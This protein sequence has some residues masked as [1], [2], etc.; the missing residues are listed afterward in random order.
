L[1]PV[2]VPELKQYQ[3]KADVIGGHP[4]IVWQPFKKAIQMFDVIHPGCLNGSSSF[5]SSFRNFPKMQP[6]KITNT[7]SEPKLGGFFA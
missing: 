3:V 2:Q 5:Q 4:L 1:E 7:T 6:L